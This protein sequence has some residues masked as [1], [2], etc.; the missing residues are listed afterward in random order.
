MS[1]KVLIVE[2]NIINQELLSEILERLK[3]TVEVADNGKIAVD[4]VEKNHYDLVLMDIQMPE[5]DGIEATKTIRKNSNE[6]PIVA[7]TASIFHSDQNECTEAG[8]NGFLTKPYT[9]DQV[10][11]MI[12]KFLS[13]S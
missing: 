2:D 11:E 13:E 6:V 4:K 1:R 10:K 3:C 9:F 8:M 12:A 7:I 5:M